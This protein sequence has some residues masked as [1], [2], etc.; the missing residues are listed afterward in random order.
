MAVDQVVVQAVTPAEFLETPGEIGEV[1]IYGQFV[2]FFVLAR[3]EMNETSVLPQSIYHLIFWVMDS[4]IY[5]DFM[6]QLAQLTRQFQHVDAHTTGILGTQFAHRA[7]VCA[8]HG[9][10]E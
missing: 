7:A 5:I 10:P 1:G 3:P 8:E 9:N 6:S 4:G 2:Y